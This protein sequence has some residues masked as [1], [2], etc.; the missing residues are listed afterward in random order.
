MATSLPGGYLVLN[1]EPID[2]KFQHETTSSRNSRRVGNTYEGLIT[3]VKQ[4]KSLYVLT[5]TGS[6]NLTDTIGSSLGSIW[7]E[8]ATTDMLGGGG[9]GS[10]GNTFATMS[11]FNGTSTTFILSDSPSASLFIS[12]SNQNLTIIP[13]AGTD[14]ITFGFSSTPT[15]TAVTASDILITNNLVV[16]G[17]VTAQ[18]FHTEFVSA[19]IIYE[20]GSTKF[21][22]SSD[23]IHEFTGSIRQSNSDSYFLGNVGIGTTSPT[24]TL[25]VV[26]S[27]TTTNL[28]ASGNISSS[29]GL[30]GQ[31][32]DI[33]GNGT[34]GG[35]L[36]VTGL[37]SAN[38]ALTT[39]NLTASGNISSSAG[40]IGQTLD[41]IGNGTIGG[42]LTANSVRIPNTL[43]VS[44]STILGD[45]ST[46]SDTLTI[47]STT[48]IND[49]LSIT[50]SL[51][52]NG[53][54]KLG[55]DF[56]NHNITVE[57]NKIFSSNAISGFTGNGW[58]I[59][60]N[61][62]NIF[63][64]DIDNINVRNLLNAVTFL[65]QQIRAT[66]G[67]VYVSSAG[68]VNST[69]SL[70]ADVN[71]SK[72]FGLIF[73]TGSGIDGHGFESGDIIRAQ[74][75]STTLQYKSDMIVKVIQ[76]TSILTASLMS[77]SSEPQSGYDYVRLGN[78]SSI[79]DRRGTVY[80][81]SDDTNS[82]FIDVVDG[83]QSHQDWDGDSSKVKVRMGNLEGMTSPTFG[84]L[85]GYGLYASGSVYLEGG[86]N[87]TLGKIAGWNISSSKI[88]K[89]NIELNSDQSF[90]R[91]GDG[92]TLTQNTGVFL[93]G[94]GEI[95][96]G[97][98]N[99]KRI[100]FINNDLYINSTNFTLQNG[101]IT[102]SNATLS[103]TITAN[104]G[105]IGG[106][107]ITDSQISSSGII[108]TTSSTENN[109]AAILIGNATNLNTGNGIFLNGAGYFRVGNPNGKR[110]RWD[111]DDLLISSSNFTL[112]NGNITASNA[113]LSGTITA[114]AGRI[115]GFAIT[116][117]AITG[118]AF[119]L[120]GSATGDGFFISAS[121][122]N[123]KA[124]GQLTGSNVLF[125]GGKVGGFNLSSDA[126]SGTGFFLS[127]SATGDG[128]FISASNFNV[129]A[130]GTIT[131]SAGLIGGFNTTSDKIESTGSF[132]SGSFTSPYISLKANGQIT[133]S[134][135]LLRRLHSDGK[136]Y[137][138]FDTTTGII[139]ARN[140]GRQVVQHYNGMTLVGGTNNIWYESSDCYY[141]IQLLQGENA[142]LISFS[143]LGQTGNGSA[144][145]HYAKI[146]LSSASFSSTII[147]DNSL[148]DNWGGEID[149]LQKSFNSLLGTR[150]QVITP[151]G[152]GAVVSIPESYQG[153]Y[154][155][156]KLELMQSSTPGSTTTTAV[157]GLT[158]TTTRTFAANVASG[159]GFIVYQEKYNL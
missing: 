109:N 6:G 51:F 45:A 41:I 87:A 154:C 15:F 31:T 139:D 11:I 83:V 46:I 59:T 8:I 115:G 122:F 43:V 133:G 84:G 127:G 33:I 129:K 53:N 40:L 138:H 145:E 13:N 95:M 56:E 50:G 86:I 35:T 98:A 81:T 103:G 5:D 26:G 85:N 28:T 29:A 65:A 49:N 92:V 1:A 77:G 108:L 147:S 74:R 73:E 94:S 128:F 68:R 67:S 62:N 10:G 78:T 146:T 153:K 18:E 37:L 101:N 19:S 30:I 80:L 38:G 126:I 149:V 135:V 60:R 156:L 88:E 119:F 21:G 131:A 25:Q 130:N 75:T 106:W 34:I 157:R 120:S 136:V 89:R 61:Q 17:R 116:Q 82:P 55:S 110:I 23:D 123:V 48:T 158:I 76:S 16:G 90:A 142:L 150:S 134:D 107:R 4:D 93:S 54:T 121:N 125:T 99:D 96:I 155:L 52:V 24:N 72:S 143:L 71:T 70:G 117:D 104:A 132:T 44:G 113:T 152:S 20:S 63:T 79:S 100:S 57:S 58:L 47:N 114:N 22:N 32:L 27:I 69:S 141:P 112:I 118:S 7:K 2:G 148:F 144:P 39:T 12:T 14:T 159:S 91:F 140:I 124:N 137:N 97:N 105:T 111:S 102:A 151:S 9:G 3:F 42:N 64:L 66:N 36:G